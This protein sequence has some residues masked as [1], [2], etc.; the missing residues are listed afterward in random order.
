MIRPP[1]ARPIA[2]ILGAGGGI[3]SPP[4]SCDLCSGTL[5]SDFSSSPAERR[6]N[7]EW[8]VK[9]FLAFDIGGLGMPAGAG[10]GAD[11]HICALTETSLAAW[12]D[13]KT[14]PPADPY[15]TLLA[16]PAPT[17]AVGISFA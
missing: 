17:W 6:L 16:L 14:A 2:S 8:L 15:S 13:F 1:A 7:M 9:D 12:M 11:M 10:G 4:P 5:D 3:G